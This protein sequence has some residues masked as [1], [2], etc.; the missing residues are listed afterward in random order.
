M[1]EARLTL[2]RRVPDEGRLAWA[3][4]IAAERMPWS[5]PIAL[6]LEAG[7]A[8]LEGNAP[9][10]LRHLHGAAAR[11]DAADMK[12]YL[13]VT[14]CRIAALQDDA[15]GRALKREAD[16]WMAAQDI[17]NPVAMTRT[18]APGFADLP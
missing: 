6:L 2:R 4:R 9:L 12:L 16:E 13:A 10:A 18:L 8:H 3:R 15:A 11:F 14:R 1:A 5:D 17:K 7:L